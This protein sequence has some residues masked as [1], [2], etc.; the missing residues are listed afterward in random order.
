[1]VMVAPSLLSVAGQSAANDGDGVGDGSERGAK[2]SVLL[3]QPAATAR[4]TNARPVRTMGCSAVTRVGRC[5]VAIGSRP[6]PKSQLG[7]GVSERPTSG[8]RPRQAA[9]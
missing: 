1:M 4:A 8:G 5:D 3:E 6:A 7:G 2:E 9:A